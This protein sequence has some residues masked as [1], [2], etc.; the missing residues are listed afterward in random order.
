[1]SLQSPKT[2]KD[3]LVSTIIPVHNREHLL[4]EAV[5]SVMNQTY[6]SIEIIIV[7]D[8]SI[9]AT[10]EVSDQLARDNAVISVI[11]IPNSGPGIA[12]ER[13]RQVAKGE[14]IQYLDSDDLLL[15]EKFELQVKS[16]REDP[17]SGVSYGKTMYS[18]N[19]KPISSQAWKRT[20]EKIRK[21]FPGF[22]EDRWWGTST[23]LYRRSVCDSVGPWKGIR[24]E[25][26]WEYDCRVALL[27][28]PL[29]YCDHYVSHERSHAGIRQ[30]QDTATN[31][32]KLAGR[33]QARINIWQSIE[34]SGLLRS[35][36]EVQHF[37]RY[38]FL[39]A[40]QCGQASLETESRELF[41]IAKQ[42]STKTRV[43]KLD[44]KL[45]ALS[46]KIIGW[47]NTAKLFSMLRK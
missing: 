38:A 26:D 10:V 22:A 35:S 25:E 43:G 21:M 6:E 42:A 8:G 12:R 44:F 5:D 40:R 30:S 47:A 1:M 13:G 27:D 20:G 36:P 14:F 4:V 29:A 23:P 33:A 31:P 28:L 18:I 32:L 46:A 37:A 3:N 39:L 19:G 11:H 7:D 34:K 24:N 15:P 2:I 17:Q 45:Y 41:N 16:L 9:D